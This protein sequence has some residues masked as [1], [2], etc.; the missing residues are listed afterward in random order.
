MTAE[1][2]SRQLGARHSHRDPFRHLHPADRGYTFV[3]AGVRAS[4]ARLDRFYLPADI[5]RWVQQCS[6]LGGLRGE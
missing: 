2:L 1:F 5:L 6:T 4:A 3:K